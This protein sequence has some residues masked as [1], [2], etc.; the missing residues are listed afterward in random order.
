MEPSALPFAT[1]PT[2]SGVPG[3]AREQTLG[4]GEA[5]HEQ[6][7]SGVEELPGWSCIFCRL[8]LSF[9]AISFCTSSIS[10]SPPTLDL[11]CSRA[12]ARSRL[13]TVHVCASAGTG[14]Q[15]SCRLDRRQRAHRA[16]D[17]IRLCNSQRRYRRSL[18]GNGTPNTT[19]SLPAAAA[20]AAAV[21]GA[22]G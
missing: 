14:R 12:A 5:R 11:W 21:N 8:C 22:A 18:V 13:R 20:A 16:G 10:L 7:A 17:L 6:R 2:P 1:L 19:G 15:P 3:W 4:K 9:G